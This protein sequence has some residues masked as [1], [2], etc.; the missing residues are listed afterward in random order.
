MNSAARTLRFRLTGNAGLAL[1]GSRVLLDVI[2]NETPAP[3]GYVVQQ[4][5]VQGAPLRWSYVLSNGQATGLQTTLSR[6]EL[7]SQIRDYYFHQYVADQRH[8]A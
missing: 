8:T 2:L 7:E 3:V 1:P 6:R 5:A 4:D